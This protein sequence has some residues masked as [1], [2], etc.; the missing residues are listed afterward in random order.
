MPATLLRP[1]T[2]LAEVQRETK[3]S[4]YELGDWYIDCINLASR[5]IE[6]K[7][8]KDFWFHDH[9]SDPYK[10]DRRRVLYDKV[11]LPFPILTLTEVRVFTDIGEPNNSNDIWG[12]DEYFFVE[13]ENVIE[14]EH[15]FYWKYVGAPGRFGNYPFKGFLWLKGT[16]GYPLADIDPNTNPPPTIPA[17]VR[18]AATLIASAFSDEL[19][20]EQVGLDGTRVELLDTRVPAE[21][22]AMLK[23]WTDGF[24]TTF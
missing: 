3:N 6:Q 23:R 16:F 7:C 15:E 10:V 21:A 4:G 12:P 19:H 8:K 24:V 9:T 1:Y 11:F 22:R 14:A 2:T 18:R 5:Y 20:K 13:G 17:E